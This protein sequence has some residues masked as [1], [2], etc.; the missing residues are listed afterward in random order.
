MKYLQLNF[1]DIKINQNQSRSHR[2]KS[3]YDTQYIK[4]SLS[5]FCV[6]RIF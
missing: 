2:F 1:V 4:V 6:L 3:D 5:K